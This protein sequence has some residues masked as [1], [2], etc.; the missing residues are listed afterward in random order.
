MSLSARNRLQ[1]TVTSVE[2]DEIMAEV[3]L[4]LDGGET[5]TATITTASCE[6]LG[7]EAGTE[8][9]AVIKASSVMIDA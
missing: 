6:R 1:G 9:D 8:V 7:L 5:I 4:E 2:F 3:E